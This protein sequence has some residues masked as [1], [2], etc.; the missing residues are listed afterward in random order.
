MQ[1]LINQVTTLMRGMWQYRRLGV[2]VAWIVAAAVAAS[3]MLLPNRFEASARVYVDTQTILR[4]LMAG[5]A[6]QPNI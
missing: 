3:V 5:L 4:P 1:E 2:L 6:V